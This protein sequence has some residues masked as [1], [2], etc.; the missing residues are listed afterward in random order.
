MGRIWTIIYGKDEATSSESNLLRNKKT[1]LGF[2]ES[3]PGSFT[4]P[5]IY[6]DSV[7]LSL[8]FSQ[9]LVSSRENYRELGLAATSEPK[10]SKELKKIL[11]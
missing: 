8:Y 9:L 4:E 5:Q 3:N 6:L 7:C 2:Q 11:N 1:T 10:Q